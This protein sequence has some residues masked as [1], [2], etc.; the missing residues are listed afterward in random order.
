MKTTSRA[1]DRRAFLKVTALAGGGMLV[2]LYWKP[3]DVSAQFGNDPA[4]VPSAYFGIAADGTVTIVAKDP[5]VGQGVKT[6]LPML[7]A[8]ELDADWTT[9]KIEQADFDDKKYFGQFAGGSMA[10]PMNWM[11]MRQVG[12]AGRSMLMAAAAQTWSVPAGEITTQAGRVIHRGSN[13]S[14]SYGEL[15]AR[16]AT[17]PVPDLKTVTLKDAKDFKIIGHSQR[18]YDVANI[19]TGK[20]TYAIDF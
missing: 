11:P 18:G 17:M 14:A 15:A 4:P 7:I 8:E 19:V 9:V 1:I 5:E 13:R 16:A 12:A 2:G 10:T 6:M 20:P 3:A